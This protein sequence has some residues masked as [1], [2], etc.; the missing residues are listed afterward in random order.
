MYCSSMESA[1]EEAGSRMFSVP[2]ASNR[3][4]HTKAQ[5]T[6]SLD[7]TADTGNYLTGNSPNIA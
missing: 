5:P 7:A 6:S 3:R 1:A 2:N 4:L